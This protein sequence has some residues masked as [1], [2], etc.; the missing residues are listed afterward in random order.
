RGP[1]AATGVR[2]RSGGRAGCG[3]VAAAVATAV[4]AAGGR[5]A[6]SVAVRRA[7]R[8]AVH[9]RVVRALGATAG[10]GEQQQTRR[11]ELSNGVHGSPHPRGTKVVTPAK[12]FAESGEMHLRRARRGGVQ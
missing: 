6:V 11:S 1:T 7:V 9:A 10:Q 5:G 3:G 4:A 8:R 2:S 12:L